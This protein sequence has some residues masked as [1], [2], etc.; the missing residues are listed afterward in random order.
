MLNLAFLRGI[1]WVTVA[2]VAGAVIALS[3]LI[4]G[5][6]EYI[7]Q[8]AQKRTELY[9]QMSEKYSDFLDICTWLDDEQK[10][11]NVQALRALPYARKV[12][13]VAFHEE[14]AMMME[15]RLIRPAVAHYMFGYY[16]ILCWESENFWDDSSGLGRDS[17]Y[18]ALF[19]SFVEQMRHEKKTLEK[20][21]F[22]SKEFRL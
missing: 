16:A 13:F 22:R 3:T 9:F 20:Q 1:N 15:S 17:R 11:E 7:K 2:A 19:H 12:D 5:T 4:K 6:L 8:G 10:E 18:W 21:K 14:L